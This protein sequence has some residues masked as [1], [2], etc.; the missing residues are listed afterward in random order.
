[1][2]ALMIAALLALAGPAWADA[3][4]DDAKLPC[5]VNFGGIY[6][7]PHGGVKPGNIAYAGLAYLIFN[8][9]GT[10]EVEAWLKIA[11]AAG[12]VHVNLNPAW[13]W[14]DECLMSV[15]PDESMVGYVS[16]DGQTIGIFTPSREFT[17][18]TATRK[19]NGR[20]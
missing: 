4:S 13:H 12:L 14:I 5:R 11:N 2:R 16:D 18:G 20:P 8:D 10:S 15:A 6:S 3:A 7:F 17:S 9:G 19:T 1:M